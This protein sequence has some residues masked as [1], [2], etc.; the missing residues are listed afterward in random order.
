MAVFGLMATTLPAGAATTAQATTA[1][2]G[3]ARG[4]NVVDVTALQVSYQG[5]SLTWAQAEQARA[6]HEQAGQEFVLVYDPAASA[7]GLAHAFDSRAAAD[8]YGAQVK[9]ASSA[10]PLGTQTTAS[11]PS[12]CPDAKNISRMYDYASCGGSYFAFLLSES[13]PSFTNVG[14]QN[15]GTSL[16]VGWTTSGCQ[17]LV[18]LYPGPNYT[19]TQAS[20]YGG[21]SATYYLFNSAQ[22]NNFESGKSSCS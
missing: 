2:G 17:A 19:Y 1:Q 10:R 16:V 15:R 3:T 9:A 4:A 8:A 22:N 21:S 7:Q 5:R 14:W 11:L 6:A 13:D 20:F 18:R 12:G